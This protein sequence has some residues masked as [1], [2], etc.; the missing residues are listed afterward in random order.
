MTALVCALDGTPGGP[1]SGSIA[2]I[3][4]QER[5]TVTG[6]VGSVRT[7]RAGPS[8]VYWC[9]L[10]DGTASVGLAFLGRSSVAGL[11][12]GVRCTVRGTVTTRHGALVIWNPR[13]DILGSDGGD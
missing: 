13:Y 8:P 9:E 1:G 6:I 11:T 4:P 12:P 3:R 7:C 5:V 10:S 2:V